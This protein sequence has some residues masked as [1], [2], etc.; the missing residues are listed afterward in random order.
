MPLK[1]LVTEQDLKVFPTYD[2]N[3]DLYLRFSKALF[4]TN[5]A[6]VVMLHAFNGY[7]VLNRKQPFRLEREDGGR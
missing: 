2:T 7:R 3:S 4:T 5:K 6:N 1:T